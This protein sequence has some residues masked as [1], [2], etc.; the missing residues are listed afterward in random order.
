MDG[1]KTNR[2]RLDEFHAADAAYREAAYRYR[3]GPHCRC[4]PPEATWTSLRTDLDAAAER[5]R[6]AA[7]ALG[8]DE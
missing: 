5:R 2:I 4:T 1:F 8:W 6:Q 7:V 3:I